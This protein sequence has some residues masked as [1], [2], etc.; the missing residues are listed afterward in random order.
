MRS[1]VGPR[2]R[3]KSSSS[4]DIYANEDE[5]HAGYEAP[6][7]PGRTLLGALIREVNEEALRA[8]PT[9]P[10]RHK[11]TPVG[12]DLQGYADTAWVRWTSP[13]RFGDTD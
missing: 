8:C 7:Y 13:R 5:R 6:A 3:F 12:Q 2:P 4:G 9:A 11:Q 1:C 10:M